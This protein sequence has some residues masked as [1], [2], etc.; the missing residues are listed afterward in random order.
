MS[1][2][3]RKNARKIS[4]ATG[5][6]EAQ[7]RI[8]RIATRSRRYVEAQIEVPFYFTRKISRV[9]FDFDSEYPEA[10]LRGIARE[11]IRFVRGKR[12]WLRFDMTIWIGKE[13]FTKYYNT[14]SVTADKKMTINEL[15]IHMIEAI[16][17]LY[18]KVAEEYNLYM[19]TSSIEYVGELFD[20]PWISELSF[21]VYDDNR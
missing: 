8:G 17:T 19:L 20:F 12:F 11:A 21:F 3:A 18:G 10:S 14:Y 2:Y 6:S 15:Y 4:Q 13:K 7:L 5:Q 1:L 9:D 16:T